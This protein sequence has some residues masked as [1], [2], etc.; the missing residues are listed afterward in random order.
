[1]VQAIVLLNLENAKSRLSPFFSLEERR[2]I[3]LI[4]FNHVLSV[5][6]DY[7][8]NVLARTHKP[9]INGLKD[10]DDINNGIIDMRKRIDDDILILPCDLPI[11][12]KEDVLKLMGNYHTLSIAPSQDDGT[13]GLYLPKG[14]DF[15]PM[16]GKGSFSLH[17]REAEMKG[18]SLRTYE[19]ENFRDLDTMEDLKWTLAH[20]GPLELSRYMSSIS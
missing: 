3:V 5:L 19:S 17:M 10:T 7:R 13:S 9:S 20:G 16:F 11:L 14:I 8:V 18:I 12:R 4:M 6:K 1:M 2:N 15:T